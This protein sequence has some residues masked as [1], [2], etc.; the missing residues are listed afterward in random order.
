MEHFYGGGGR[1]NP[2][3]TY[4]FEVK[5]VTNEMYKW[6]ED[7]PLNGPFER[8]YIRHQQYSDAK[9]GVG[10]GTR[11]IVQIESRKAAYLFRIAFSEY[12]IKDMTYSF[13]KDD[14]WT[15]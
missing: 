4:Q 7:Y 11:H 12:I 6:L 15:I 14:T 10:F 8:F 5:A 1:S 3:F 13:A 2:D 9:N